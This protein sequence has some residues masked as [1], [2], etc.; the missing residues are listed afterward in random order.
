MEK[1]ILLYSSG[2]LSRFSVFPIIKTC[3]LGYKFDILF[4]TPILKELLLISRCLSSG[5]YGN[6]VKSY[7]LLFLNIRHDIFNYVLKFKC[8]KPVSSRLSSTKILSFGNNI[9]IFN[10]LF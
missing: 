3:K 6:V 5:S 1:E 10:I 2:T 4:S 9:G 8:C 7:I